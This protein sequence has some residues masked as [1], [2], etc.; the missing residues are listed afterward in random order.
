MFM[1]LLLILMKFYVH[2]MRLILMKFYIHEIRL[3][4]IKFY[5]HEITLVLVLLC[6]CLLFDVY[7]IDLVLV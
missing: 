6:M 4:L 2:E 1:K 7:M 5:V 3:I